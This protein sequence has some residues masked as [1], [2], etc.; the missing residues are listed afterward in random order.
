MALE[1][2]W[3]GR[4]PLLVLSGDPLTS[5]PIR[6]YNELIG[7]DMGPM[8]LSIKPRNIVVTREAYTAGWAAAKQT[9][10]CALLGTVMHFQVQWE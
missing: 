4:P 9:H 8:G 2:A 10:T 3:R 1:T 6:E 7:V 5:T